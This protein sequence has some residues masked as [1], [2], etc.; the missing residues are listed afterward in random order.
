LF[1]KNLI[2]DKNCQPK[3]TIFVT[4]KYSKEEILLPLAIGLILW[5]DLGHGRFY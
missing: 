1:E 3:L 5:N 2:T 4:I